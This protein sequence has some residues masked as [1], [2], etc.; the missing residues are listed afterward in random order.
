V[1][2]LKL[3]PR[4]PKFN[5]FLTRVMDD[6]STDLFVDAPVVAQS[7]PLT[8]RERTAAIVKAQREIRKAREA[9]EAREAEEAEEA[10]EADP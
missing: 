9:R 7:Q 3:T 6:I 2:F 5:W 10:E 1:N 4:E 8:T